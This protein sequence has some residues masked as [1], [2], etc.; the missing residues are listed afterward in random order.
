MCLLHF[1]DCSFEAIET[2]FEGGEFLNFLRFLETV[3]WL[4]DFPNLFLNHS[5]NSLCFN[6][7]FAM[8]YSLSKTFS[9]SVASSYLRFLD[10]TGVLA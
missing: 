9:S 5:A 2:V 4:T 6:W 8:W 7:G 1:G 10:C 3:D